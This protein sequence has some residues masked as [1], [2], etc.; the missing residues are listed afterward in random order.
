MRKETINKIIA[1]VCFLLIGVLLFQGA[2]ELLAYDY[3]DHEQLASK[4]DDIKS[5]KEDDID[6][7]FLGPSKALVGII[8]TVVWDKTGL[9]SYI[10]SYSSQPPLVSLYLL[11]YSLKYIKPKTVFLEMRHFGSDPNPDK[12]SNYKTAYRK[13]EAIINDDKDLFAEYKA[14]LKIYFPDSSYVNNVQHP[15]YE[16]HSR[17]KSLE[18]MDFEYIEKPEYQLGFQQSFK[19]S[20][21]NFSRV[22]YD[23]NSSYELKSN[24]T[25]KNIYLEFAQLCN[26]NDIRL[27]SFIPPIATVSSSL[28]SNNKS[29]EKFC[30]DL[31]IEHFDFNYPD[32]FDEI[33][34]DETK[35]F[36]NNDHLNVN[37]AYKFSTY[38]ANYISD[39]NLA[40]YPKTDGVNNIM[41]S[42]HAKQVDVLK[43]REM[44]YAFD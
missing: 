35:D 23:N 12:S 30:S 37:G 40:S 22:D 39:H 21:E 7:L 20:T 1:T 15:F 2:T 16:F 11:K 24:E 4:I 38:L 33:G 6:I 8:P 18:K 28:Y 13:V 3:S 44:F 43:S 41:D 25:S 31:G 42:Y 32:V 9:T 17:W 27:I 10:L 19:T 5:F 34:F 14:D 36:Y 29:T 26:D